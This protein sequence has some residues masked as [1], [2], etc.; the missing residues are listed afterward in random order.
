MF[1][2]AIVGAFEVEAFP[3]CETCHLER[4]EMVLCF[5]SKADKVMV[6]KL[7]RP[8]QCFMF[9]MDT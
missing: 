3:L 2:S 5:K 8:E 1:L 7:E 9:I 4:G 6:S